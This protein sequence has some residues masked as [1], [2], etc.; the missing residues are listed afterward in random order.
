MSKTDSGKLLNNT[1]SSGWCSVMTYTGEMG[2]G[3]E[4]EKGRDIYMYIFTTD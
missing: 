1:E 2:E 4:A 3:R